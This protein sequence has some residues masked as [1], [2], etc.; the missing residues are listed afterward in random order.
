M[1]TYTHPNTP[2]RTNILPMRGSMGRRAKMAPRG[3]SLSAV[4]SASISVRG[5]SDHH[6]GSLVYRAC[7]N[8]L[9]LDH[10]QD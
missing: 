9:N 3:V 2:P 8:K 10:N 6:K 1:H 7:V 5:G 4:S